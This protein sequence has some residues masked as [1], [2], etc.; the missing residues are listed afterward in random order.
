MR[1]NRLFIREQL[2]TILLPGGVQAEDR[3][4][5]LRSEPDLDGQRLT[6]YS[7]AQPIGYLDGPAKLVRTITR[8]QAQSPT[9]GKHRN[10]LAEEAF[11]A[12]WRVDENG[13]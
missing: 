9:T 11:R 10:I 8:T 5:T 2:E 4:E 7:Y 13:L 3:H 12:G 1:T 6:L